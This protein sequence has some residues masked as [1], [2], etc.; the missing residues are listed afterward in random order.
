[1]TGGGTV[2]V[3]V[4][5]PAA[6]C[7][8]LLAL[9]VAG[10][11][12]AW[13]LRKRPGSKALTIAPESGEPE[14]SPSGQA[15]AKPWWSAEDRRR[16]CVVVTGEAASGATTL[17]EGLTGLVPRQAKECSWR[18]LD[19]V[20][21]CDVPGEALCASENGRWEAALAALVRRRPSRPVDGV[22]LT[23]SAPALLD[24][25]RKGDALAAAGQTVRRRLD[26]LERKTGFVVPVYVVITQCDR[27]AGFP[28]LA[29]SM[30]P[31]RRQEM[32]GWS[33]DRRLETSFSADWIEEAFAAVAEALA[34]NELVLVGSGRVTESARELLLFPRQA[35]RLRSP[36]E[37]W[38]EPVFRPSAGAGPHVLRGIYFCG[39]TQPA[40]GAARV[41]VR[42][43]FEKKICQEIRI[44]HPVEAGAGERRGWSLAGKAVAAVL[45]VTL[46]AGLWW[47]HHRLSAMRDT[48]I[49]PLLDDLSRAVAEEPAGK[50]ASP[51]RALNFLA[52]I[53]ALEAQGF[54][55]LFLPASWTDP[56]A[57]RVDRVLAPAFREL[58]VE[59]CRRGLEHRMEKLLSPGV[60][61]DNRAGAAG[62]GDEP[63]TAA[64]GAEIRA[65]IPLRFEDDR[66]YVR[67]KEFLDQATGLEANLARYEGL[68][69]RADSRHDE[70]HRLLEYLAGQP[71]T[72]P[73][74]LV[75][76]RRYRQVVAEAQ[77]PSV[78]QR[79]TFLD[80]AA[81]RA[82]GLAGDFLGGWIGD[83]PLPESVGQ[84]AARVTELEQGTDS[85][86]DSLERLAE[87]IEEIAS[88][89]DDGKWDWA[90]AEFD[91]ARWGVL[92]KAMEQ[93]PFGS[94]E[95]L[96]AIDDEGVRQ[97]EGLGEA[98]REAANSPGG[99]V[100]DVSAGKIRLAA[101]V[102]ELA[103]ALARLRSFAPVAE[104][105][106]PPSTA[107]GMG[108]LWDLAELGDVARM[109]TAYAN[110]VRD[111]LPLL[112]ARF[113]TPLR[114]ISALR[115]R[116][117]A[118]NNAM[119]AREANPS[120]YREGSDPQRTLLPEIRNL[121]QAAGLFKDIARSLDTLG[122]PAERE[123]LRR[124]LATQADDLLRAV[125]RE[126]DRN[127]AYS[128]R[129]AKWEENA[130]LSLT[131]YD[132]GSKAELRR[133]LDG[134]R[135]RIASLADNYAR[136]LIEVLDTLG[137]KSGRDH[138]ARWDQIADAL[139]AYAAARPGNRVRAV[140][141][142]VEEGLDRI[143]PETSCSAP[144]PA[145]A[146]ADPFS[147]AERA[148]RDKAVALC[149]EALAA[150]YQ[151]IAGL[152][153]S[154]LAGRYPF[155]A[156]SRPDEGPG[157]E[158]AAAAAFFELLDRDG[159]ALESILIADARWGAAGRRAAEFL[160][161]A[162]AIRPLFAIPPGDIV[163]AVAVSA[164]FRVNR[165]REAGAN[166]IIDWVLRIGDQ[167]IRP[168]A[169][170][171]SARWRH[172][173]RTRVELR[174]AK[175][176]PLVP[177]PEPPG[178][179]K[180]DERTVIFDFVH[181][182]SLIQLL[183]QHRAGSG[184]AAPSEPAANLLRFRI[185]NQTTGR[186]PAQ[187]SVVFV[188]LKL[189]PVGQAAPAN[190][191]SRTIAGDVAFPD[192]APM[193]DSVAA[194]GATKA[195]KW[196]ALR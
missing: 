86:D 41:F 160:R 128:A 131:M 14:A 2:T 92:G 65:A 144:G 129:P 61:P 73:S 194:P 76:N 34:A 110:F 162:A 30:E 16:P 118:V 84:L 113:R 157:V 138:V 183:R 190:P 130:P 27:L 32:L 17:L 69:G 22:V 26:R 189:D 100:V 46:G 123:T 158:T 104:G 180:I 186:A 164:D 154:S 24:P 148:I 166:H 19:E 45:A 120:P 56:V 188:R 62:E 178:G 94:D 91:R 72:H 172:G 195:E 126:L 48:R 139:T 51:S 153:N 150:R 96:A 134:E 109:E 156:N 182:W 57:A 54:S 50:A 137:L 167:S 101:Q 66:R 88:A 105:T 168:G 5:V 36:F 85:G 176:S 80:R 146:G 103:P 177:G 18:I 136:P 20:L 43:L 93:A 23:V 161:R 40:A 52:T 159:T 3:P 115:V 192:R 171:S 187:A 67:V 119:R 181:P 95:L 75:S 47:S 155:T 163:P 184:E 142:L 71:F 147:S 193:L 78:R 133:Y 25:L 98:L 127:P 31:G 191:A 44:A 21:F 87:S 179:P 102:R 132:A 83:S 9:L 170:A 196:S 145:L 174:Y 116:T 49:E 8:A 6:L 39:Q 111:T 112:P 15:S 12:V 106:A 135:A 42:D 90:A 175:D 173:D 89:F 60:E 114:R 1:M 68:A 121:V 13:R 74:R 53:E 11:I 38:L 152:F 28:A 140:E 108:Y 59:T 37:R 143:R 77:W 70:L 151:R 4:W 169:G 29:E 79:E 107:A 122:A 82:R 58:V 7:L 124:L 35:A 64:A 125:D 10:L 165:A 99:P 185:P 149:V 33:S 81:H 117:S 141:S 55:S 97:L 63:E